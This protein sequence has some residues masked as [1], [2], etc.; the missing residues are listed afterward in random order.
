[1]SFGNSA[2]HYMRRTP[3]RLDTLLDFFQSEYF[4]IYQ[5]H[6]LTKKCVTHLQQY[7]ANKIISVNTNKNYSIVSF[8]ELNA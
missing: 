6:Y 1:M 4:T 8:C 2:Q 3:Y 7:K 5:T